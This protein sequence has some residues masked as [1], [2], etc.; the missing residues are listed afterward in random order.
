MKRNHAF[1]FLLVG[2]FALG[3]QEQRQINISSR[4][5]TSS[6]KVDGI[7]AGTTPMSHLFIFQGDKKSSRV[8]FSRPGYKDLALDVTNRTDP[9]LVVELKPVTRKVNIHVRPFQGHIFIDGKLTS[10]IPT[11]NYLTELEFTVDSSNK[12]TSHKI[13]VERQGFMT[14]EKVI[15]YQDPDPNYTMTLEPMRK[16]LT[17]TTTPPGAELLIDDESIGNSPITYRGSDN[18]GVPFNIDPQTNKW[19]EYKLRVQKPGYDPIDTMLTWNEG[20]S[21][22]A[23]AL[24]PKTKT[25]HLTTRPP[26]AKVMLGN[27]ELAP[28]PDGRITTT[29]QFPPINAKGDLSSHVLQ[30]SKKTSASEWEP[31]SMTIGWDAGKTEYEIALKEIKTTPVPLIIADPRRGDDGWSIVKKSVVTTAMKEVGETNAKE[32][33]VRLTNLPKGTMIDSLAISPDGSKLVF[34]VLQSRADSDLRS[35]MLMIRTDGTG[36]VDSL[37]DGKSLDIHPVFT[38]DGRN[39][40]FSSNRG[41]KRQSIW[42]MSANGAPGI[43]QLTNDDNNDLWP[44]V[45]AARHLFYQAFIDTRPDARLFLIELGKTTRTDLTQAGGSQPRVSP[46]SR[47]DAITLAFNNINDKTQKRDIF[48]IKTEGGIAENLTNSP[49]TDEFDPAWNHEGTKLAYVS[50][51]GT[52]EDRRHNY[53]IWIADLAK[54]GQPVQLTTNGSWDDSPVWDPSGNHIYFRS[55]RGGEWAIWKISVK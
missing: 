26:A 32:Q 17:I 43:T 41:G 36:G 27:R 46:E 19:N 37:S 47:P 7:D 23:I 20:K 29:L 33:P 55:N 54:P 24:I 3:C 31:A 34:T 5:V 12:W 39:V 51:G 25:I 30:L 1:A 40:V 50:D 45:D 22:Y 8:E 4:P 48:T 35:Q 42:W 28:D 14:A 11:L 10:P 18:K 13:T 52:D 53:D 16:E 15:L 2:L 44:S 38:K 6:V 9:N 21:E 49:D